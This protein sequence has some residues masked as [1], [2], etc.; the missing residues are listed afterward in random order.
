MH[1]RIL[2]VIA[3]CGLLTG[4]ARAAD[5]QIAPVDKSGW[6]QSTFVCSTPKGWQGWKDDSHYGMG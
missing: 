4:T 5:Y 3:F 6:A 2:N 1:L